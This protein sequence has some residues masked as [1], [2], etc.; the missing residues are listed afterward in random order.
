M[1]SKCIKYPTEGKPTSY[2]GRRIARP[3]LQRE[4]VFQAVAFSAEEPSIS[5]YEAEITS[6]RILNHKGAHFCNEMRCGFL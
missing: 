3:L 1:V 4:S 2:N 6:V 5:Q